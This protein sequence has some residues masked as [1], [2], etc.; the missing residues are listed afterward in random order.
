MANPFELLYDALKQIAGD[1]AERTTI[2]RTPIE[3]TP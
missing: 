1:W 3:A 2:T